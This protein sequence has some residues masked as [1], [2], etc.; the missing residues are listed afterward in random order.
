M[1]RYMLFSGI[2]L[3]SRP[4]VLHGADTWL[5]TNNSKNIGSNGVVDLEKKMR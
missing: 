5:L 4:T 2:S 1:D 3:W